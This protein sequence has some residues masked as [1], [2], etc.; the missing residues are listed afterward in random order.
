[1]ADY[2][3]ENDEALSTEELEAQL[4][5]ELESDDPTRALQILDILAQRDP[6]NPDQTQTAWASF[7]EH[8]LPTA[9]S[10]SLYQAENP[11]PTPRPRHWLRRGF[12]IAAVFTLAACM[13]ITQAS[14]TNPLA[15]FARWTTERFTFGSAQLLP[16]EPYPA[17]ADTVEESAEAAPPSPAAWDSENSDEAYTTLD[18]ALGAFGMDFH[19]PAWLPEGYALE[20]AEIAHRASGSKLLAYYSAGE[21]GVP[22]IRVTCSRLNE[23]NSGMGYI[24]EKDGTPVSTFQL[25]DI[26]FY[27]LSNND[28]QS[29]VWMTDEATECSVGGQVPQETLK[30]I[31]ESM[32]ETTSP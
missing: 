24:H 9:D 31:V 16:E 22:F 26:C 28:F 19:A 15:T 13:L 2:R 4:R 5:L 3:A 32:Y 17:P 7:Q 6:E 12:P 29:I 1:M 25:G 8:Y 30:Q 10:Y 21:D 14:G 27:Q 18:E 11:R 23:E 20:S